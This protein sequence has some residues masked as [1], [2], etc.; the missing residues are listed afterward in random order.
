M[1]KAIYILNQDAFDRV[2]CEPEQ[3]SI[4]SLVDISAG[5]Y[6]SA[7][8]AA[9]LVARPQI[10]RDTEIIFSGWGGPRIDAEF[11]AHAPALQ[12]VLYGA[13]SVRPIVTDAFWDRGVRICSAY[14]ANAIPVAEFVLANVILLLKRAHRLATELR[15]RRDYIPMDPAEPIFGSYGSTVGLV[16]LG[17]TGRRTREML[18]ALDVEVIAYDPFVS[19]EQAAE[20]DVRL[21]S[22]EELFRAA[23]VVSL[24]TP[25]LPETV[26]MIRGSHIESMKPHSGFINSSR[27]AIVHEDELIAALQARRDIQAILDV[28]EPEPPRHES[29]FYDLPNVV[30]TPHVAGS[31]GSECRRMGRYMIEECRRYL[32]GEPLQWEIT[33]ARAQLLG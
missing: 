12:L 19:A 13:G 1:K 16:S 26:G 24:H 25:L 2:Y 10:L 23:D 9:E 27:G 5:F 31:L 17:M 8:L 22:L 11:L 4:R 29:A 7:R 30:L 14:G 20:L 33:R 28:T 15:Q 32:N 18:R 21:V 6:T 3:E